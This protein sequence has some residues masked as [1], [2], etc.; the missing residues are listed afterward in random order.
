MCFE[1][2]AVPGLMLLAGALAGF[3][4]VAAYRCGVRDG[5]ALDKG[6]ALPPAV[7]L[8]AKKEA[9]SVKDTRWDTI[10][11]NLEAYDGSST[12]QREVPPV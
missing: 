5:R 4:A 10:M 11:A 1:M 6:E 9:S 8:P 7:Q 2:I 3:G 12:G